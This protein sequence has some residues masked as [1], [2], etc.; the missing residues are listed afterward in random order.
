MSLMG[1]IQFLGLSAPEALGFST[2]LGLSLWA[3]RLM[4]GH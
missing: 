4:K 2:I 1:F 3:V